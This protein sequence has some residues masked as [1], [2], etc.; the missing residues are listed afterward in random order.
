MELDF[1]KLLVEETPDALIATSP[2]G[3]VLHWN[4]GA[5]ATFGYSKEEAISAPLDIL[6]PEGLRELHRA[7]VERFATGQLVARRMG[8]RGVTILGLRKNGQ[9]FPAEA[10]ISRLDVGG[11]RILTVALRD[12]TEQKT[13][14]GSLRASEER[15]RTLFE[16]APD[17]I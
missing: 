15:F 17:A 4:P 3:K 1:Q 9:E 10:A 14:E 13:M 11:K 7:H 16:L 2:D 8:E 12:I 5:E 6:I